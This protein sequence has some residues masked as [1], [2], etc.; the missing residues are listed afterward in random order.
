MFTLYMQ[1]LYKVNMSDE[2]EKYR[3]PVKVSESIPLGDFNRIKEI[4]G[5]IQKLFPVTIP[6]GYVKGKEC[7]NFLIRDHEEMCLPIDAYKQFAREINKLKI[8]SPESYDK[9][10]NTIRV[11][12]VT[13]IQ[14]LPYYLDMVSGVPCMYLWKGTR[15]F[16]QFSLLLV[17]DY[18][19]PSEDYSCQGCTNVRCENYFPNVV[20]TIVKHSLGMVDLFLEHPF[21]DRLTA[22]KQ[23]TF[24]KGTMLD[25]FNYLLFVE[26]HP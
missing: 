12:S 2:L 21:L 7:V 23:Y 18:H 1:L 6:S 14:A 26:I 15:D 11:Q 10:M 3:F 16:N 24:S 22:G 4:L 9:I 13:G 20:N 25:T 5:R 19:I 8:K 17:G